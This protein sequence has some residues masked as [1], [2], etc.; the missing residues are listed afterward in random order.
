[1]PDKI[2]ICPIVTRPARISN[3]LAAGLALLQIFF[4]R[5]AVEFGAAADFF[6][7][8]VFLIEQRA[9]AGKERISVQRA[10]LDPAG[11]FLAQVGFF[12]LL[13]P[14]IRACEENPANGLLQFAN[15]S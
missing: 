6:E 5:P 2:R 4:D 8:A 9:V 7:C 15:V 3:S 10:I 12:A 14:L 13:M 1:M 11:K